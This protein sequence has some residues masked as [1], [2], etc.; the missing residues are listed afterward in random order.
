MAA[1][2]GYFQLSIDDVSTSVTLYPPEDGGEDISIEE[3]KDY[4]YQKGLRVD[5]LYLKGALENLTEP[6]NLLLCDKRIT[7]CSESMAVSISK[8]KMTATVRFY[9][10]SSF[11]SALT[12]EDIVKELN[13]RGVKAGIDEKAISDYLA[14]KH[15]CTNY[16][17]AKGTPPIEGSDAKIEYFFNTNPSLKPKLNDD[18]SVDFFNLSAISTVKKDQIVARLTPEVLGKPGIAV[19]GETLKPRDVKKT[20]LKC[21]NFLE[22]SEDGLEMKCLQSGHAS[23]VDGRVFVNTVYEVIN[24]DNSTGNIDYE[25]DICIKGN[26]NAGFSVKTNG[27]IEVKGVVEAASVEATGNITIIRGMNGMGQ[28]KLKAGGNVVSKFLENANVTADGYV[29]AEAIMHSEVSAGGDVTVSG[30]RGFIT[31]GIVRSKGIVQAKTIGSSMGVATEVE[32]G[33]DPTITLK[34]NQLKQTIGE[35]KK[36]IEAIEPTV[37]TIMEKVKA[38]AKLTP[39]Q[40]AYVQQLSG[41][42]K[43]LQEAIAKSTDELLDLEDEIEGTPMESYILIDEFAYSGTKVTVNGVSQ[44]LSKNVQHSRLVRDGADVRVTA[45]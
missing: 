31:G 6:S 11:G 24:V 2:N 32:V 18:G 38:G 26:V 14:D 3:L 23:V 7:P 1:R 43:S 25:G 19:T 4:L 10:F 29:H 42:Y 45:Y 28:G 39:D 17:F 15:Y 16:V 44:T 27:N 22:I 36:K 41:Q 20:V 37:R 8:D 33:I 5:V 35:S 30:K 13:F 40:L 9:P 21:G 12:K 34:I